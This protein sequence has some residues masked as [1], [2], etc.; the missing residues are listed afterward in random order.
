MREPP[1]PRGSSIDPKTAV[2]LTEVTEDTE[3]LAGFLRVL[4]DLCERIPFGG[5]AAGEI[6]RGCP[7]PVILVGPL[8]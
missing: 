8:V 2:A 6:R 5:A 1:S 4:R 3:V 7:G